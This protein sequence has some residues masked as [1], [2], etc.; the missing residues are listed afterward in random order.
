MDP[1]SANHGFFT[2]ELPLI[3]QWIATIIIPI[4]YPF[5]DPDS[6]GIL[7]STRSWNL[8]WGACTGKSDGFKALSAEVERTPIS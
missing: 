3:S 5:L 7:R 2:V 6:Y 4:H 1:G 8:R